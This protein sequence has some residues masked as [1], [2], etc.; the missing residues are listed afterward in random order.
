MHGGTKKMPISSSLIEALRLGTPLA[1][2]V[3]ASNTERLA[4]ILILPKREP[5]DFQAQREEWKANIPD[6]KF[7][8]R[9]R[10]YSRRHIENSWDIAPGDGMWELKSAEVVG[11]QALEQLLREWGIP[12]E[13]LTYLWKTNLPE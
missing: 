5:E 8:V 4:G 6:R 12:L 10:E 13:A 3:P 7:F 1:A 9:W 2:E 11:E